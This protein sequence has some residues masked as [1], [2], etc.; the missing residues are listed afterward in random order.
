MTNITIKS[1]K[2][3]TKR[4]TIINHAKARKLQISPSEYVLLEIISDFVIKH[5]EMTLCDFSEMMH[6]YNIYN[7]NEKIQRLQKMSLVRYIRKND[8]CKGSIYVTEAWHG[9]KATDIV[10]TFELLWK[11]YKEVADKLSHNVGNKKK[12]LE[13]FQR[14]I[15]AGND[16]NDIMET[17]WP[18]YKRYILS[19]DAPMMH[20]SSFMNPQY[21]R[22]KEDF[23]IKKNAANQ[24]T[25]EL[26]GRR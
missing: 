21:E 17:Y 8:K 14:A 25:T 22:F 7:L 26:T 24:N 18:K 20:L 16:S 10:E 23:K 4:E 1:G 9:A 6:M 13:M 5:G 11:Q 2:I 12:G 19:G 15:K 3:V